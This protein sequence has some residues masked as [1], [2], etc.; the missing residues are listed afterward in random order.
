[1]FGNIKLFKIEDLGAFGDFLVNNTRNLISTIIA[2]FIAFLILMIVRVITKRFIKRNNGIRKH[3][4]TLAKMIHSIIKYAVWVLTVIIILGVWG[5]DVTPI[6]AGAGILALAISLG[7]QKL[8]SDLICGFCIV[9][10]NQ[11]DVDDVVEIDG[12]K[13]RVDEIT[14]RSTKIINAKNEV[15]IINNGSIT[16]VINFSKGPSVG[17]VDVDIAYEENIEHVM[18]VLK[19][20]LHVIHD[21][22]PQIIE[23]PNVVGVVDLA[24]SGVTIRVN[25]KTLPEEHYEVERALKKFIKEL[26]DKENIEIPFDQ[27]VVRN[28]ESNN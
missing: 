22:Y 28:A 1:M 12:F 19:D 6:L 10:E 15:K 7:A 21:K 18:K 17:V 5:L 8:I 11:F 23:G 24:S 16:T 20:N 9:F 26:F 4:V 2:L 27:L 3:A 25:V 14:L 13:G